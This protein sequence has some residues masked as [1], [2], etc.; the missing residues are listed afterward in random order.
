MALHK[1]TTTFS[2]TTEINGTNDGASFLYRQM[3]NT[4]NFVITPNADAVFKP[5]A[6][7]P[8]LGGGTFDPGGS[9]FYIRKLENI[10]SAAAVAAIG[11]GDGWAAK[12][13]PKDG[14]DGGYWAVSPKS[15]TPVPT[16]QNL[17][18]PV[19]NIAVDDGKGLPSL[20]ARVTYYD[21]GGITS[22]SVN[23]NDSY[24]LIALRNPPDIPL[25]KLSKYVSANLKDGY[26]LDWEGY[27]NVE[28]MRTTTAGEGAIHNSFTL[29]IAP[30]LGE[31]TKQ[32]TAQSV[33]K[34]SF[35]VASEVFGALASKE[36]LGQIR[37][38]SDYGWDIQPHLDDDQPFWAIKIPAGSP[39][40]GSL[41][42][43]N[44]VSHLDVGFCDILLHWEAIPGCED[45]EFWLPIYKFGPTVCKSYGAYRYVSS[46]GNQV[47]SAVKWD[48]EN[49]TRVVITSSGETIIDTSDA[50]GRTSADNV[51]PDGS[52]TAVFSA[53]PIDLDPGKRAL[54]KLVETP[55][56]VSK[57]G[58]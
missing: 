37:I 7:P 34:I 25:E 17:I 58:R 38:T 47:G 16:G 3:I 29:V 36:D 39:I 2:N 4:G 5:V 45:G 33:F 51:N 21:V 55:F 53:C 52:S 35:A 42:F 44:V 23:H 19:T 15:E 26:E 6:N 28:M 49:V 24:A 56:Y 14:S 46:F 18:I 1:L 40:S 30:I 13:Y 27:K 48:M 54:T 11:F 50:T 20:T 57:V 22:E 8:E 31:V 41:K 43:S 32:V 9:V 12:Y 10:M